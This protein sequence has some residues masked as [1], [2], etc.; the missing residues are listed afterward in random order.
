MNAAEA[1]EQH[2]SFLAEIGEDIII[3]RWSGTGPGRTK[4]QAQVRARVSGY[5]PS[6][7]IGA[8]AQGDINVIALNDPDAEVPAGMVPL[9][10]LFPLSVDD[11]LVIRGEEKSIKG[12]NDNTRRVAGVLIALDIH[13]KG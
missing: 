4:V 9:S 8:V 7:I 1:L 5:T 2:R 12:I 3:R 13:A 10:S 11:K 6:Q